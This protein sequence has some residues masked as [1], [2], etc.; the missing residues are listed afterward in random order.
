MGN[1][2]VQET[3]GSQVI[4][5]PGQERLSNP[6]YCVP[7]KI[8]KYYALLWL[9][10]SAV[11]L[12]SCVSMTS[13]LFTV[14][15]Q[16]CE[17]DSYFSVE[18]DQS[19][20][21]ALKEPVLSDRDV[22][23]LIGAP[24]TSKSLT[25]E[26]MIASYVFEQIPVTSENQGTL[27]GEQ[28]EVKLRFI[29]SKKGYLLSGIKTSEIPPELLESTFPVFTDTSEMAQQACDMPINLLSRSVSVEIGKDSLDSLPTRQSIITWLGPPLASNDIGNDLSYE[30]Q[31]KGDDKDLHIVR[32]DADYEQAGDYP[33]VIDASFT[34][35]HASIDVPEGTM[36]VKLDL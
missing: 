26:G 3:H 9:L 12:S 28:F 24:P 18:F 8:S 20:E 36:R 7:M 5:L 2:N 29:S 17:F 31:L 32:V 15:K 14:R 11:F 13:H 34:R 22:F 23:M 16:A 6:V 25:T 19:V 21:V 35:Y 10:F 4:G 27:A 33:T 30:F 1:E